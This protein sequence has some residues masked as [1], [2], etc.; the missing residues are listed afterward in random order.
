VA[1][2]PQQIEKI[3]LAY[4]CECVIKPIQLKRNFISLIN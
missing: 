1:K 4:K 3:I 2:H